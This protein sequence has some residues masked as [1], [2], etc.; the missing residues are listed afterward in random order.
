MY[1]YFS[2]E[3]NP[4]FK[5]IS[6]NCS[7][8]FSTLSALISGFVLQ[9]MTNTDLSQFT[10]NF[11]SQLAGDIYFVLSAV[12]IVSSTYC[13]QQTV[14]CNVYALG[15]ALRGPLG[16]MVIAVDGLKDEQYGI[17]FSFMMAIFTF[18]ISTIAFFWVVE[19]TMISL[20]ST[21][22]MII[23]MF[24]WYFYSTRI[25]NRF[26]WSDERIVWDDSDDFGQIKAPSQTET[27][28]GYLSKRDVSIK[29]DNDG[30][31][32]TRKYFVLDEGSLFYY[33]SKQAADDTRNKPANFRPIKIMGYEIRSFL[34]APYTIKLIPTDPEDDR[35]LWEFRCDTPEELRM[36][37][38]GLEKASSIL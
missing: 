17:V 6:T 18:A 16:S 28:E 20:F 3:E 12:C 25:I 31:P 11:G 32:W 10:R 33:D 23:G 38:E 7:V 37:E 15:L 9:S 5:L 22:I 24:Y 19:T 26:Q 1:I 35:R 29:S 36:W 4:F 14:L 2:R 34:S 30:D 21:I 8:S 13:L 27:I